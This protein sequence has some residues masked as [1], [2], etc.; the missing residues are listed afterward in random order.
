MG[1]KCA[2]RAENRDT[3]MVNRNDY[4]ESRLSLRNSTSSIENN[5]DANDASSDLLNQLNA[6]SNDFDLIVENKS[7]NDG[8]GSSLSSSSLSLINEANN[9]VDPMR[10]LIYYLNQ[11]INELR[12][13]NNK[14]RVC[15]YQDPFFARTLKSIVVYDKQQSRLFNS[16]KSRLN[17][18]DASQLEKLIKWQKVHVIKVF[19]SQSLFVCF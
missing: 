9:G 8:G 14:N 19:N 12:L 11:N 6:M 18:R 13:A 2:G 3:F 5:D 1:N 4:L 17:A 7:S 15:N 10:T 16:L